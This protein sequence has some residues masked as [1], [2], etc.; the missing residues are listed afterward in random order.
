[1]KPL[2][3]QQRK[4]RLLIKI[5]NYAYVALF[6]GIITILYSFVRGWNTESNEAKMELLKIMFIG[7]VVT[8]TAM[9]TLF[10]IG[11]IEEPKK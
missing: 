7:E 9:V 1:M 10:W 6:L 8:I 3:P 4:L 11:T 5:R 2:S